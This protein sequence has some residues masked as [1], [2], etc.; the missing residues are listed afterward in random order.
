M[1]LIQVS[2]TRGFMAIKY[3]KR[4]NSH[5]AHS[6]GNSLHL[7]SGVE[8]FSE[9]WFHPRRSRC[10]WMKDTLAGALLGRSHKSGNSKSSNNCYSLTHL[11]YGRECNSELYFT[12]YS[13]VREI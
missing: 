11:H 12:S 7:L 2:G 1:F 5:D 13:H 8:H 3:S 4:E 9:R 10:K 6:Y